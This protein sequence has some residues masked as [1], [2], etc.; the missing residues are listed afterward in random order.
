MTLSITGGGRG[1]Q[2]PIQRTELNFG[3]PMQGSPRT[4]LRPWGG[5]PSHLG[6]WESTNPNPPRRRQFAAPQVPISHQKTPKNAQKQPIFE[7]VFHLLLRV[8]MN[9]SQK[10]LRP[11]SHI[12]HKLSMPRQFIAIHADKR[13]ALLANHAQHRICGRHQITHA[14][15]SVPSPLVPTLPC[16]LRSR[17]IEEKISRET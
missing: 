15:P 10:L 14:C 8:N 5:S 3:C 13:P 17:W 4:G 1:V 11:N 7:A 9:R 12:S 2:L 6:R 16:I